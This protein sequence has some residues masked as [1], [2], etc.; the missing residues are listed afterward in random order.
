MPYGDITMASGEEGEEERGSRGSA[1]FMRQVAHSRG[2][3]QI[4][5]EVI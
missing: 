4:G 1:I 5:L 3:F 2:P